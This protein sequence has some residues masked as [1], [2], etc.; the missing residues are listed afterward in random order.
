MLKVTIENVTRISEDGLYIA[1]EALKQD[2]PMAHLIEAELDRRIVLQEAA[3]KKKHNE[4][5]QS[6]MITQALREEIQTFFL[7]FKG[8][9]TL[10]LIENFGQEFMEDYVVDEET[11]T[12]YSKVSHETFSNP[13]SWEFDTL[14]Q[15]RKK[16]AKLVYYRIYDKFM[17]DATSENLE[18]L[19][20]VL[21]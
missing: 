4:Q 12:V 21:G 1:L 15:A 10:L 5:L 8:H 16:V 14:E 17:R 7:G 6:M 19:K 13:S 18:L 3:L 20:R 9:K 2:D 11:F